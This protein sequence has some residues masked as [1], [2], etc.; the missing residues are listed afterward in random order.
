MPIGGAYNTSR[1]SAWVGSWR[2]QLLLAG[3]LIHTD[4]NGLRKSDRKTGHPDL[5]TEV[6]RKPLLRGDAISS[7]VVDIIGPTF[8]GKAAYACEKTAHLAESFGV[9]C[10]SNSNLPSVELVNLHCCCRSQTANSRTPLP[11]APMTARMKE[12]LQIDRG[13]TPIRRGTRHW[14]QF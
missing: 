1:L 9:Q 6:S 13:V 10:G 8:R 5:G 11:P 4:Y 7:G 3:E 2:A 12:P 14:G